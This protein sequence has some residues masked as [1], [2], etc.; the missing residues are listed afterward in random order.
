[1]SAWTVIQLYRH[2]PTK[3]S[4]FPYIHHVRNFPKNSIFLS[5]W[6]FLIGIRLFMC[7]SVSVKERFIYENAI[8]HTGTLK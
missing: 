2:Y 8:K 3:T 6:K 5:Y 4:S 1:M 7:Y